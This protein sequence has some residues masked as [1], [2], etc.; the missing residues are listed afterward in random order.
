MGLDCF[1]IG[2]VDKIKSIYVDMPICSD[3]IK[4]D[5]FIVTIGKKKSNSVYHVLESKVKNHPEKSII[6]CYLKVL[7]TTLPVALKRGVFQKLIPV[8]WN[9]R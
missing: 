4:Q 2:I 8:T 7:N 6:R 9:K 5:D 3:P 1:K